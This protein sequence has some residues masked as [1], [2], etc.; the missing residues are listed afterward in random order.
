MSDSPA[1]LRDL[2]MA[3]TRTLRKRWHERI[4]PWGLTPH[5]HRALRVIGSVD[6]PVRLGVV[7]K[8][9][10]IVP[11]SATEVV[12]RLE[13]RGL[14]ERLPDPADRRAV[15]VQLTSDGQR[16]LTELDTARDADAAEVFTRLDTAERAELARL[17]RKLTDEHFGEAHVGKSVAQ[18]N[19]CP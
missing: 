13:S 7:A 16:L 8:S 19:E 12:D 10:R 9:L 14:T 3:T 18:A 17:L 1:T 15:C 4:H 11:R 5:E 6:E 2:L